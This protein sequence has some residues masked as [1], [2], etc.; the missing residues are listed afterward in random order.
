VL[1]P[2]SLPEVYLAYP[3]RGEIPSKSQPPF[4]V[5]FLS[6]PNIVPNPWLSL[7]DHDDPYAFALSEVS[8]HDLNLKLWVKLPRLDSCH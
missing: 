4:H 2:V 1:S 8:L 6:K 7:D 3:P 5:P